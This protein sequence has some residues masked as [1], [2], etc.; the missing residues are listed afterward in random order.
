MR[1]LFSGSGGKAASKFK[2]A[3]MP[4]EKKSKK[5]LQKVDI[6]FNDVVGM[7]KAKEEVM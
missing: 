5:F 1:S 2:Q 7:Q 6:K 3:S 4:F